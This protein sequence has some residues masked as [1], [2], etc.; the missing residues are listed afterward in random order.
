MSGGTATNLVARLI[1]D[2]CQETG[3]ELARPWRGNFWEFESNPNDEQAMAVHESIDKVKDEE[4]L[5]L[6]RLFPVARRKTSSSANYRRLSSK[7][8]L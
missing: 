4:N 2:G 8:K 5:L 7:A 6:E 1:I 3:W